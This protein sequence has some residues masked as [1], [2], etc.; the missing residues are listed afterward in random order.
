LNTKTRSAGS[1]GNVIG[2]GQRR[3]LAW[4]A[5]VACVIGAASVCPREAVAADTQWWTANSAADHARA[6]ARGIVVD[7][8]GVIRPGPRAVSHPT[9]SLSIAWCVAVLRDGSVA[10][11]GDGGRVMRWSERHGWRTWAR[12]G[13]GQVQSLAADGDG[14]VAGVGPR[15][16]VFRIAANGDTSRLA[17]TGERHVWG[18]LPAGGGAW[19]AAT[20]TRGRLLRLASGRAEVLLDTEESNLVSLVSDGKGGIYAGG[21]SRGRVYHVS[22]SGV[23]RTLFDAAEDEVRALAVGADGI[24]WAAASSVAATSEEPASEEGPQPTRAAVAGGRAVLYRLT[25]EGEASQWWTSPQPLVFA[26]APTA[27]GVRAA[28]GNRAGLYRIERANAGLLELAPPQGQVTALALHGDVLLAVTSN[29]VTLWRLGPGTAEGGELSSAVQ[30]ARRFARFGRLRS[31]GSGSRAF[32]T[33][34]GNSETPDTTWTRWQPVAGDGEIASPPGRYLQWKVRLG[35][36]DASVDEVTVSWREPNLAPRIEDLSVAAQGQAFR[37]GEM[38]PRTESV[39]QTLPGGQK[40]EYSATMSG[41]RP[42]RELPIWA[43]GLRTLSW[44]GVDPN[45]D[46]LRYR[47]LVRSEPEGDW[48]EIGKELEASLL[49]WN[50]NTLAD[51]RYRVKVE[52]TDRDGNAV[53]EALSGEAVSEPFGVDNHAP[54]VTSLVGIREGERIVISGSASDQEGWLQRLDLSVDDGPWRSLAPEGGFSDAPRLTFRAPVPDL[55]PGP[56]LLSVRAVDAAGN[57]ATR[58]VRV[59]V[60]KPR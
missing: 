22:A 11:G 33:R 56:H 57:S 35:S 41:S 17:A 48:I 32:S 52:A 27:K 45:G 39:T 24:V 12:L 37:E 40:V 21:D 31:T 60:P 3:L 58:A 20:G 47:V 51:G 55:G 6:E 43:R 29:P 25:P 8:D 36:A 28:T 26:L 18:L 50:T 42:I 19:Y 14:A 54:E 46:P 4:G 30:D 49:T 1:G 7:P 9:D 53:G 34:S 2:A 16:L 15:G 44:R 13:P 23:A 38:S 5:A 10:V 59:T